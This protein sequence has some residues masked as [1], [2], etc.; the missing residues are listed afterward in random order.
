MC[1][2]A[3]KLLLG[4]TVLLAILG[5]SAFWYTS[6]RSADTMSEPYRIGAALGL[7]GDAAAWGAAALNGAKLAL[8]EINVKGDISGRRLQLQ[9]EDTG[10]SAKGTM[11]AVAKLQ[12]VNRADGF[13]VTW[14]DVYQGAENI[15]KQGKVMVSPDAG[16]EAVNGSKVHP[17]V[18]STWY[19]TQPK[20]ELAVQHMAATGKKKLYMIAQNDSYYATAVGFMEEAAARYGIEVVGKDMLNPGTDMKTVLLKIGSK[21]PDAVFFAFYD[22][23][24][25]FEFL[26]RYR[27]FLSGAP[28]IY[29]DEFVQQNYSRPELKGMLENV[30]FYAPAQPDKK[31]A[32]AYVARYA[33]PPVFGASTAYDAIYIM[34]RLLQ[35]H[36]ADID[37]YMRSTRF[38]TA[39]Y[40]SMTFDAIGGVAAAQSYFTVKQIRNGTPVPVY[41]GE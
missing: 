13:L 33:T 40:G 12:D 28:A 6:D 25:N 3:I 9:V 22:D 16:V 14:L 4:L 7:T 18:F 30:L 5:L 31:F 17:G 1:V 8:E 34:A 10:S 27:I 21:K 2:P 29:G 20:S 39:S 24:M 15:L 26:K 41:P 23:Q 11:L 37:S 35:D 38:E 36:P 19:R 32:E